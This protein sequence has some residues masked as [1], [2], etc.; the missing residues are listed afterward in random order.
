MRWFHSSW[1]YGII[2]LWWVSHHSAGWRPG[3]SS[4]RCTPAVEFSPEHASLGEKLQAG[5]QEPV[6]QGT[7]LLPQE[8]DDVV[9]RTGSVQK[10][11]QRL[12]LLIGQQAFRASQVDLGDPRRGGRKDRLRMQPADEV[13][14][15]QRRPP[16]PEGRLRP[17]TFTTVV[18]RARLQV[19]ELPGGSRRIAGRA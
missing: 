17:P 5:D 1:V 3:W 12:D 7:D 18:V 8:R 9:S 13:F 16:R 11:Q 14:H 19:A 15:V 4:R 2:D 6:I 10:A